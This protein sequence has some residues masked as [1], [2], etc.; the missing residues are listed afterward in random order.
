MGAPG[1]GASNLRHRDQRRPHAARRSGSRVGR[2]AFMAKSVFGRFSGVSLEP[3]LLVFLVAGGLGCSLGHVGHELSVAG[4]ASGSLRRASRPNLYC[5][6]SAEVTAAYCVGSGGQRDI[7]RPVYVYRESR[8]SGT[9]L[10][11]QFRGS[12]PHESNCERPQKETEDYRGSNF[13]VS[14]G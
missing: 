8:K 11:L 12:G 10:Q 3:F 6:G 1:A 13:V 7:F 4:D 5:K 14:H 9:R 2:F